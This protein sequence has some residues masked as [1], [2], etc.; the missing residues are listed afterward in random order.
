[1]SNLALW[2]PS[3]LHV[4]SESMLLTWASN[5]IGL[6]YKILLSIVYGEERNFGLFHTAKHVN[7]NRDCW[8]T[9]TLIAILTVLE[10][11]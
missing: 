5:N 11:L 3:C 1:M 10:L 2:E 7:I 9:L 4:L 6:R 8:Q